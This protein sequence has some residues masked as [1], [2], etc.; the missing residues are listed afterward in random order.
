MSIQAF[1]AHPVDETMLCGGTLAQLL[2]GS[3]QARKG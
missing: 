1:F 2:S 3:G